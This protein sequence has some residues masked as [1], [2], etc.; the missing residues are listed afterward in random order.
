MRSTL[1]KVRALFRATAEQPCP[2]AQQQAAEHDAAAEITVPL[3]DDR[4][5]GSSP[6]AH[7]GPARRQHLNRRTD[8]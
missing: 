1:T 8:A 6:Y 5:A 2:A 4:R 7:G 3:A